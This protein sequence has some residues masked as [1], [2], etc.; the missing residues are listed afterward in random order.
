VCLT[1]VSDE[2]KSYWGALDERGGHIAAFVRFRGGLVC[3]HSSMNIVD[4]TDDSVGGDNARVDGRS[5]RERDGRE[6]EGGEVGDLHVGL[7]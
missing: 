3:E 7:C 6:E 2:G 1:W 4:V 5:A